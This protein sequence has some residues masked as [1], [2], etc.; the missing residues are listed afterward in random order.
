M[1]KSIVLA[2]VLCLFSQLALAVDFNCKGNSDKVFIKASNNRYQLSLGNR[3][4]D[5]YAG[6]LKILV[7]SGDG[8][9]LLQLLSSAQNGSIGDISIQKNGLAFLDMN[10]D[11]RNYTF[12]CNN[13]IEQTGTSFPSQDAGAQCRASCEPLRRTWG[14]QPCLLNCGG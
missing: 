14:Y 13:Y 8:E 6:K 12:K 3:P 10:A 5:K 7:N 2:A 1:K 11:G 4:V 9:Q